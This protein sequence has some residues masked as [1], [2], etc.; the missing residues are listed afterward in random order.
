MERRPVPAGHA[1]G[2]VIVVSFPFP[3]FTER[4]ASWRVNL[5][6]SDITLDSYELE[7]S[8]LVASA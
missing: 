5:A 4:Q 3:D 7:T 6:A 2:G 1:P 8:R